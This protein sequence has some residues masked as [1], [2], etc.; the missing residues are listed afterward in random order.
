APE[1]LGVGYI[2]GPRIA[3]VLVAGGVLGWLG[4]IPLIASLVPQSIIAVQLNKLGYLPDLMRPGR[5]G[6]N[7]VTHT[8][9]DLNLAIYYA[10]VRQIGAGAVASGGGVALPATPAPP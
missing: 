6:W 1:Y 8:F 2:I 5:Y 7:P 4:L 9:S 3:G 10:Y